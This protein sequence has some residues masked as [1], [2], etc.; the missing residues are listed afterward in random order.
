M[1]ILY[2]EILLTTVVSII[3]GAL[4][5]NVIIIATK[6]DLYKYVSILLMICYVLGMIVFGLLTTKRLNKKIF[7]FSVYQALREGGE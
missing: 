7:K 2:I 5:T 6:I 1:K 4:L 3:C